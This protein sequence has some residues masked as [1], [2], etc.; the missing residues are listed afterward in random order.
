MKQSFL[1]R[2]LHTTRQRV[3]AAVA[4]DPGLDAVRAK[5][6]AA[7]PP[8]DFYGALAD[9]THLS[10]IAEIKR[11]SPS[12]G[13]MRKDLDAESQAAAYQK[14][15]ASALS[16]LTEEEYFRGSL[17]DLAR[18]RAACT[19]P[20]LRK[21]FIIHPF[22][23]YEARAW[24]ADAVLLI[25]AVLC[26][27]EIRELADVARELGMQPLVEIH[28][29]E[30]IPR[31]VDSGARIIGIN[32]RDLATFRV[33]LETTFRLASLL[34]KELLVISESGIRG[35][36]EAKRVASWGVKGILVGEAL[37][38]APHLMELIRSLTRVSGM[39]K[40]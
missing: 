35:I 9:S 11:A 15:G 10:L 21:D 29:E 5:A 37:V 1:G 16:V 2:I 38:T 28:A 7:P 40:K 12:K 33:D 18:A 39:R 26:P 24:G 17:E 30:E 31:A 19:L 27:S 32:N 25:A 23:V 13:T 8:R 20:I 3:D 14:F 34:P 36:S 22:Q 6:L 4:A